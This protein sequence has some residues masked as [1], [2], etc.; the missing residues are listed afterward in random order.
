MSI[1]YFIVELLM[2]YL[3]ICWIGNKVYFLVSNNIDNFKF[4]IDDFWLNNN[5]NIRG[6]CLVDREIVKKIKERFSNWEKGM[7]ILS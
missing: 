5:L 1:L 6:I 4:M 2:L 3:G 7:F